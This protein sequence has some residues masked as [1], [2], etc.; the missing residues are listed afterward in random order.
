MSGQALNGCVAA[1]QHRAPLVLVMHR[2]GIQ[3][4]GTTAKIM[5]RDP[6]P[7]VAAL[8]IQVIE[9][10]S[11]HDRAAL[12]AAYRDALAL[13][14]TRPAGAHLPDRVPHGRRGAHHGAELRRDV[15]HRRRGGARSPRQHQVAL[16]TEIWIPGSLMSFRDAHAMCECL[17][18]VNNLPGGEGHHDGG[19]KGRD[20]AAVLA[21]PMLRSTATRRRRSNG[22]APCRPAWS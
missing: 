8:G 12:F 18:Y 4:S 13:A 5:D 6:R 10:A 9:I 14:R 15:R 16:D 19:M 7:V 2:N 11:L 21:N 3:L 22:C 1:S 20:E 17:F